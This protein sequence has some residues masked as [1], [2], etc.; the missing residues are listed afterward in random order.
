[1]RILGLPELSILGG[2]QSAGGRLATGSP[3]P[4]RDVGGQKLAF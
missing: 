4:T 1:M 3:R 2:Q